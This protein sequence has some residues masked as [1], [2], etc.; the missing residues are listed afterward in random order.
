MGDYRGLCFINLPTAP[1][2]DMR[3]YAY[4]D[5]FNLYYGALEGTSHK[6]L[7]V[8]LLLR[9]VLGNDHHIQKIKSA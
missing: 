6:W 9:T 4:I 1:P 8:K 3:T 2:Q 5:G 7:D